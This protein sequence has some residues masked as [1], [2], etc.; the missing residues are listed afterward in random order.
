MNSPVPQADPRRTTVVVVGV[1]AYRAGAHWALD[2]PVSDALRFADWF[3]ARGVPPERITALLSAPPERTA[4]ARKVPYTVLG[5]DRA[6]VHTTLLR[7]VAAEQSELLWV[8]W[9][10]H[11]VVDGEGRRRLF[12]A[13]A[14][15]HDPINLDFD[16]LLTYYRATPRHPRQIWLVDACQLLHNSWRARR[17][18]PREDYGTPMARTAR[19][20]AVLFAAR[21]GEA[22]TNL[23]GAG[24]GLFS[25][26]ALAVL[27]DDETIGTGWPPDP[28]AVMD[29]LR[30]RFTR[31]RAEGHASQTPTYLW[32]RTWDGDEAQLLSRGG[33]D[34]ASPSGADLTPDR[35][36]ALTDAL[37][38]VEE[39]VEPQGREE[40]LG[41]LR[42]GVRAAIARHSRPRMDT[43]SI[44]R[45]CARRPGALRELA[46]AVLLCA[47]GS[48]QSEHA[49]RL[50]VEASA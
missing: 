30:D 17:R 32:S 48:P 9:G 40:I 41:L 10:G 26:E 2:G 22:A 4:A 50:I 47:G 14:T 6:T 25:R 23:S 16:A 37:L 31:L 27:T 33:P 45:T 44:L 5:A 28:G 18:L 36:R 19:D 7:T 13:D 35:L 12:Y 20:Q 43:I 24:T 3:L 39:F 42:I 29:R 34:P 11:G 46:E 49:H 38:S 8:V 15:A 21:P 1:D